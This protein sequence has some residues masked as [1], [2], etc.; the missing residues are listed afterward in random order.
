MKLNLMKKGT[1]YKWLAV[2][3]RLGG[4]YKII[5]LSN[6]NKVANEILSIDRKFSTK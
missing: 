2:N 5:R 1:F 6:H 3:N 4:Q